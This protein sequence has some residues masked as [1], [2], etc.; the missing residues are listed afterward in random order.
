MRQNIQKVRVHLMWRAEAGEP[1]NQMARSGCRRRFRWQSS[2]VIEG[3]LTN[4]LRLSA[5]FLPAD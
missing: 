1:V 3:G 5:M 4:G 2:E